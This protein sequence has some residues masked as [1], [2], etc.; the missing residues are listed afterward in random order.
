MAG[1][2]LGGVGEVAS[3]VGADSTDLLI[4]SNTDSK[5]PPAPAGAADLLDEIVQDHLSRASDMAPPPVARPRDEEEEAPAAGRGNAEGTEF[6]PEER[7]SRLQREIEALLSSDQKAA[8][9]TVASSAQE[10]VETIAPAGAEATEAEAAAK[11]AKAAGGG[12]SGGAVRQFRQA[13]DDEAISAAEMQALLPAVPAEQEQVGEMDAIRGPAFEAAQPAADVR[14]ADEET[15]RKLVE[16]EGVAAEELAQ[17]TEKAKAAEAAAAGAGSEAAPA[18]AVTQKTVAAEPVASAAT[19][20]TPPPVGAGE[21][22]GAASAELHPAA[23]AAAAR[24]P[25][26]LAAAEAAVP[27]LRHGLVYDLLLMIAQV[28]DL[29][30][31]WVGEVEKHLVGAA[32]LTMLL[33]GVALYILAW[34][35]GR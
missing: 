8:V 11:A 5:S 32:A 18:A 26:D 22:A 21:S 23:A 24:E 4:M 15:E 13:A 30:F 3:K 1:A 2:D 33:S 27:A 9:S 20:G 34:M 6:S 19:T 29:P 17:L 16:A 28:L 7:S 35:M 12:E 14:I 31:F 25:A 10:I